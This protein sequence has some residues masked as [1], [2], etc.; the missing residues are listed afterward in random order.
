VPSRNLVA[1]KGC[2]PV[3][4]CIVLCRLEQFRG[5][6]KVLKIAVMVLNSSIMPPDDSRTI[7]DA[8][9]EA[10]REQTGRWKVWLSQ[11]G[12]AFSIRVDGPKGAGFAYRFLKQHE[13][14]PAFG[15]PGSSRPF[16][17]STTPPASGHAREM[18]GVRTSAG[19]DAN[20]A[21]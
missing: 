2:S 13:R 14:L 21:E 17:T 16:A 12:A 20:A 19:L 8:V 3:Q 11:D 6:W 10:I 7:E 18:A 9:V 4:R 1:S 5:R 15:G